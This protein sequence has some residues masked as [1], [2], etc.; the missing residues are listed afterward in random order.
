MNKVVFLLFVLIITSCSNSKIV[1]LATQGETSQKIFNEEIPMNYIDK[2][3][4]VEAK[5]NDKRYTFLFDTGY[6]ITT[7]DKSL[8][9]EI[10][11]TPLKKH[12]TSGSSFEDI[13]LQYGVL[14]SI[15]IG[16]IEFNNL[17]I[18]LQDLSHVKSPFSDERKIYGI[19]GTNIL[20][21]G[22]W[23][24]DYTKN[25]LNFSNTLDNFPPDKNAIEIDMIPKSSTNWGLNRIKVTINGISDNFVFDTGS[26][27][28]FSANDQFLER[29][30]NTKPALLEIGDKSKS[31]KRKFEIAELKLDGYK[32]RNQEILIESDID[33]LIGNDFLDEYIVTI[34]WFSNKLYLH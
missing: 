15:N 31:G 5:I 21:K 27:C 2:F 29:L 18:G 17:G 32:V 22:F 7:L 20:R 34:D 11:F 12:T 9:D 19:I 23:Q 14:S 10:A 6:D 24:I 28:S 4:F 13:K 1:T 8:I 30:N 26:Y 33:L 25:T 16:K 3:V